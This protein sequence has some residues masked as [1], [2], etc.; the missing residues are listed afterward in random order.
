MGQPRDLS[1][2][3]ARHFQQHLHTIGGRFL[4]QPF[5]I[6]EIF[7]GT[8]GKFVDLTTTILISMRYCLEIETTFLNLFLFGG[9]LA[10]VKKCDLGRGHFEMRLEMKVHRLNF[11]VFV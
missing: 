6:A 1:G 2:S 5:F 8:S 10:E 4:T 7:T 9:K 3:P 11:S